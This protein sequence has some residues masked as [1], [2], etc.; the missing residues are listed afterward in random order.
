M[1]YWTGFPFPL[2][3]L[4]DSL[5]VL[6][7]Q[8]ANAKHRIK[9][10]SMCAGA[11]C[12]KRRRAFVF[13]YL[14]AVTIACVWVWVWLF[15]CSRKGVF[16][17][18]SLFA[19]VWVCVCVR[20]RGVCV[21]VLVCVSECE[22]VGVCVCI[23]KAKWAEGR[24]SQSSQAVCQQHVWL[25]V[26]LWEQLSA[27]SF[28]FSPGNNKN[29]LINMCLKYIRFDTVMTRCRDTWH[30]RQTF[31][32]YGIKMFRSDSCLSF[33]EELWPCDGTQR[34]ERQ[35]YSQFSGSF[36]SVQSFYAKL[37]GSTPSLKVL[38]S[39]SH[40]LLPTWIKNNTRLC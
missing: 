24:E 15:L 38:S 4:S 9:K 5:L 40:R 37:G 31:K 36:R 14:Y 11:I 2:Q 30:V 25:S 32:K 28:S 1:E 33:G 18:V 3:L 23:I 34:V 20:I 8:T 19:W 22:C 21:C 10:V 16:V 39:K 17:C 35:R 29:V 13:V 27:V 7:R 6:F 12:V 26:P